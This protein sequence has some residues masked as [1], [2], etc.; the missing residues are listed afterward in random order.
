MHL[1]IYIHFTIPPHIPTSPVHFKQIGRNT[2]FLYFLIWV[3]EGAKECCC[4]S[5]PHLLRG[6]T[7]AHWNLIINWMSKLI[8]SYDWS[9]S[10]PKDLGT[11]R[12]GALRRPVCRYTQSWRRTLPFFQSPHPAIIRLQYTSLISLAHAHI[13]WHLTTGKL[14]SLWV[15]DWL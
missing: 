8:K 15:N 7:T 3:R 4:S 13:F 6:S 5:G 9:T 1:H 10:P 12:I 14:M 11:Q 2:D